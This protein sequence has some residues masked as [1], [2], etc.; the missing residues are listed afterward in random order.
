MAKTLASGLLLAVAIGC[1]GDPATGGFVAPGPVC[2]D[3][4]EKV[5]TECDALQIRLTSCQSNCQQDVNAAFDDSD[6]CGDGFEAFYECV[7][8]LTCAEVERW[9]DADAEVDEDYPCRAAVEAAN[10]AC[11][12]PN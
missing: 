7:S 1:G 11:E 5:V 3:F 4:C 6:R 10:E 8:A 12:P 9:R 2:I